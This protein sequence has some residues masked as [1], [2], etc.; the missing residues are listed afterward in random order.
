MRVTCLLSALLAGVRVDGLDLRVTPVEK[1]TNLLK[2]LQKQVEEEGKEE[3]AAYDKYA[4]FCKEQTDEKDYMIDKSAKKIGSLDTKIT[5]LSSKIVENEDEVKDL[6]VDI[7]KLQTDIKAAAETRGEEHEAYVAEEKDFSSAIAALEGAIKAL[8]DSKNEMSGVKLDFRQVRKAAD[9]AVVAANHANVKESS[10]NKILA[11]AGLHAEQTPSR[12]A[13]QSN[14]ILQT[15]RELLDTFNKKKKESQEDEFKT[16]SAFD[17][18]DLN[19]KNLK[20]FKLK[21]KKELEEEIDSM[22]EEKETA[23][24]ER[25]EELKDKT[26][27]E[28]FLRVLQNECET[29]AFLWDARS[30]TRADELTAIAKAI[31]ALVS[32]VAPSWKANKKLVGLQQNSRIIG[33]QIDRPVSFLQLR[34]SQ[35]RGNTQ[36]STERQVQAVAKRLSDNA[37][38]LNS[39]ILAAASVRTLASGDHFVKVRSIIKDLM[40]RLIADKEAEASQKSQCDSMIK[41]NVDNRDE[42]KGELETLASTKHQLDAESAQLAK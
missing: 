18:Q 19:M 10:L 5:Y 27:D 31:D 7:A 2:R 36:S 41:E 29:K 42:A 34:G 11:L 8:E 9:L 23:E 21:E 40:A 16:K 3:A 35:K 39:S 26:S 13:Y 4:C 1:V 28:K 15:L 37:A 6:N 30:K 38:R 33:K 12:Y 14:D 20:Q 24:S 25:S 17:K 32:S 22:S